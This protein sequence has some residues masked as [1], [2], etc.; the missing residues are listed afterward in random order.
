MSYT[1]PT[2]TAK[3]V[4]SAY[5]TTTQTTSLQDQILTCQVFNDCTQ[6][7]S[8]T[9]GINLPTRA[10]L[11]GQIRTDTPPNTVLY[12]IKFDNMAQSGGFGGQFACNST[13]RTDQDDGAYGVGNTSN[14]F[15]RTHRGTQTWKSDVN[16]TRIMGFL[17]NQ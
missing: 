10:M 2:V 7:I 6:S 1:P 8:V 5:N 15:M 3:A 11:H 4:F 16:E 12:S 13:V 9:G 17:L 14:T